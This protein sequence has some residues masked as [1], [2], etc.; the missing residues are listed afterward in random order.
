MSKQHRPL[1][2]FEAAVGEWEAYADG[3]G[4]DVEKK[5]QNFVKDPDQDRA[6]IKMGNEFLLK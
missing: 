1:W 2:E 5:Y 4:W 3:D 6:T